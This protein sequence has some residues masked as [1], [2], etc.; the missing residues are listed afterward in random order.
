[1]GT[2][3]ENLLAASAKEFHD[4]KNNVLAI[5]CVYLPAANGLAYLIKDTSQQKEIEP[6]GVHIS[7]DQEQRED[8]IYDTGYAAI[9]TQEDIFSK[10]EIAP[11]IIILDYNGFIIGINKSGEFNAEANIYH[12]TGEILLNRND[13][14]IILDEDE[15][16]ALILSDSTTKWLDLA[17]EYGLDIFP[18]F[19]STKNIK[20][21][22]LIVS[23][24]DSK[25][26]NN[27]HQIS[28]TVERQY[29][30]DS[31]Q[32][33]LVNATLAQAQLL[34]KKIFETPL[35]YP[36]SFGMQDFPGWKML[37]NYNQS[38]FGLKQNIRTMDIAINY[39][40]DITA[41]NVLK[42]FKQISW[43]INGKKFSTPLLT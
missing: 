43:T 5:P 29:K 35:K 22:H 9:N 19:V 23:I 33:Y 41:L 39:Q 36:T 26:L 10:F 15:A 1:M 21:I 38:S 32:L 34:A 25:P 24:N 27:V 16:S 14:Y 2:E 20:T 12:Y 11:D 8:G 7:V 31:I 3:L 42:Y 28:D 18:S 37:Q 30:K 40:L 17:T 4:K 6:A 13:A